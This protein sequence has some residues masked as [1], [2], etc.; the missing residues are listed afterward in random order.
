[1]FIDAVDTLALQSARKPGAGK[2]KA[3]PL[4]K[5]FRCLFCGHQGKVVCKMDKP[6]RVGRLDCSDCGQTFQAS[7]TSGWSVLVDWYHC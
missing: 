5:T 3:K 2:V 1:M 6:N 4:D 7:I